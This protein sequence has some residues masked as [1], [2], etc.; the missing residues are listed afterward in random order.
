MMFRARLGGRKLRGFEAIMSE[1]RGL[2]EVADESKL[3]QVVS[4][5]NKAS[6]AE[7]LSNINLHNAHH[8]G[9]IVLL[10]KLQ[11]SWDNSKGVS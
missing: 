8:G 9:Q 7:L 6:W 11:G 4:A 3:T 2:I 1:W 10:R 5:T